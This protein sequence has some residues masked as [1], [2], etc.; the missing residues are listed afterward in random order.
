MVFL[1]CHCEEGGLPDEAIS[2]LQGDCFAAKNKNA[3]RN[4]GL[5]PSLHQKVCDLEIQFFV[6]VPCFGFINFKHERLVANAVVF[7]D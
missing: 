2:K 4:D 7:A 5:F 6:N 1:S 3:A